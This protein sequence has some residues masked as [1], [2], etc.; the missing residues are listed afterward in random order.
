MA[1]YELVVILDPFLQDADYPTQLDR[2]KEQ[3]ARRGGEV[4]NI[5]IWGKKRLAY[6]IEKK[7][8]GY[9]AVV[10]FEGNLDGAAVTELERNLRLNEQILRSMI[11]RVPAPKPQR[12]VKPRKPRQA[13][14]EAYQGGERRHYPEARS[15]GQAGAAALG[16]NDESLD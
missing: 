7:G 4:A 16:G 3:V 9:Y 2:V 6:M 10:T 1:K 14:V 15:A 5:D 12:K 11:T 8:E 13:G